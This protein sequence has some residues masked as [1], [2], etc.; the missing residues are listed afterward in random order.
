[1]AELRQ[2]S[3]VTGEKSKWLMLFYC[4]YWTIDFLR[5][6]FFVEES[7]LL[8]YKKVFLWVYL[9]L[10]TIFVLVF[11]VWY[12]IKWSRIL[13]HSR[14]KSKSVHSSQVYMQLVSQ[15]FIYIS[16]D[17]NYLQYIK[18][19]F[20]YVFLKKGKKVYYIYEV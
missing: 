17:F 3:L 11:K 10:Y 4:Y 20:V 1:M 13:I 9:V 18:F 8:N 16:I 6:I 12:H 7:C 14:K 5:Y 19:G 2:S 15:Q